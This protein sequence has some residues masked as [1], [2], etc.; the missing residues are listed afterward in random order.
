MLQLTPET[1]SPQAIKNIDPAAVR[2]TIAELTFVTGIGHLPS[3]FSVVELLIVVYNKFLR[4]DPKNPQ[5]PD[6]DY[7]ILSK[8]H[9]AATIFTVLA[10]AGYFP[11]ELLLST[12]GKRNSLFGCHPD[13]NKVPGIEVS[14][15]S[16]GHGM[17]LGI[18][19][20]MGLK[21]RKKTNKV[22]VLIGDGESNEGSIWEAAMVAAHQKLDNVICLLDLNNSQ[23]RCLPM[24][25]LQEK[26]EA[27]GWNVV[28]ADG[29]SLDDLEKAIGSLLALKNGKP[30]IVIGNTVKG[31]GV[32]FLEKEFL[33]WHHRAPN[34]T[35]YETILKELA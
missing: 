26:W 27:F 22:F 20:A 29:H 17:P 23:I 15:G 6:R 31:K 18:G 4:H 9:A 10:Y 2:R 3:C 25:Q 14:T 24:T 12:Y 34:K 30:S 5:W 19:I 16:L 1:N 7:F 33:T 32:S 11:V 13:C 28:T 8:G 35:E 21:I